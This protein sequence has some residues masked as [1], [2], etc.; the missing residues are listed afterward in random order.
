MVLVT[1]VA[2]VSALLGTTATPAS[3]LPNPEPNYVAT[4]RCDSANPWP[5]PRIPVWVDVYN[6]I[7]FPSDGLPGPAIALIG[8]SRAKQ[9][10][11]EFTVEVRVTWRNLRTGR[12]GTVTVPSRGP[13]VTW[14]VVLHP[15]SGPVAFTIHQKIGALAFVPMV[16]PQYSSCSGRALA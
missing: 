13:V 1:V 14:Q 10:V 7:A 3:A 4:I 11:L 15:G 9:A 16:N 2:A 5:A 12:Q 8:S 6:Q